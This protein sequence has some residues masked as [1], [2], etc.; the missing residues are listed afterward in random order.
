MRSAAQLRM[1]GQPRGPCAVWTELLVSTEPHD[2]M[3]MCATQALPIPLATSRRLIQAT[4]KAAILR[5]S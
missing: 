5:A 2:A 1:P 4:L 3:K